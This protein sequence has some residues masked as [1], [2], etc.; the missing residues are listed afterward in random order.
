VAKNQG[1]DYTIPPEKVRST[2]K[3]PKG[4]KPARRPAPATASS[5]SAP[6]KAGARDG[7]TLEDIRAVKEVVGRIGADKVQELAGILSK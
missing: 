3:K 2:A 1:Y 5:N 6:A 7:I 4:R